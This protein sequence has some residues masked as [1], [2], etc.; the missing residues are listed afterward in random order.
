[1]NINWYPGHMKKTKDLLLENLKLVDVIVEILDSRIP[2][3]SKN[4]E[5]QKII[6]NKPKIVVLNKVDL[7]N[8]EANKEWKKELEKE[9]I[10][11]LL[12]NS[13]K[14]NETN[15]VTREI[16]NVLEERI[17]LKKAKGVKNPKI[18]IMI[19]GIPNV[20]KSTLINS[21]AKR[22]GARTG[23]RP[24]V[25]KGKQWI[26][27]NSNI[28]LLDTPG[29]LWPKIDDEQVGINLA[30]T[31]AIRD[32]ILDIETLAIILIEKLLKLDKSILE[33]RYG[34]TVENK[35]NLEIMEEIAY[36][37][38]TILKQGEVD[39]RRISDLIIDEFRNGT[40]GR[41]TLEKP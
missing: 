16:Y 5:L 6:N 1:M 39:Y 28:E 10:K 3:S 33:D 26:K 7:S 32:E 19:V 11:I 23:N 35:S 36:K 15:K 9:S 8:D 41:I 40:L 29:I 21:L 24:G 2:K 27:I 13:L 30:I 31:G 37:R 22:K 17:Q 25:T 18:R 4:P 38:G 34:I 12:V 20:G 14:E